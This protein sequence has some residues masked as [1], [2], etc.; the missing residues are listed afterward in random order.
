[1][2][3]VCLV[4]SW[5]FINPFWIGLVASLVATATEYFFGDNGIVKWADD[6]WAIP[7][8]SMGTILGLLAANGR[9]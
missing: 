8:L 9:L 5:V 1:M 6:N 7:L 3:I 4:I 2:F